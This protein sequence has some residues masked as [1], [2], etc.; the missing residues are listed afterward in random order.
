MS[1]EIDRENFQSKF[2][3]NGK[4]NLPPEITLLPVFKKEVVTPISKRVLYAGQPVSDLLMKEVLLESVTEL[5]IM[6]MRAKFDEIFE[7]SGL[8][9]E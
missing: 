2:E 4:G 1:I 6:V 8:F 9:K 3:L 5:L 7:N